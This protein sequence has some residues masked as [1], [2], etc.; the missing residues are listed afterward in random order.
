MTKSITHSL[1]WIALIGINVYF[2]YNF[3]LQH[4]NYT[5]FSQP[6]GHLLTVHIVFGIVAILV[7]PFQ[8]FAAIRKRFVRVHR[9]SGR[10]YLLSVLVAATTAILLSVNDNLLTK[11]E[12]VFGTGTLG[13][14]AAWLIT[15]GMAF[16]AI[17]TR[18]FEQHREWM[19]RS[20]VVTCGFTTF[21]IIAVTLHNTILPNVPNLGDAAAW[22]CWAVPLLFTEAI[23]QGQKMMRAPAA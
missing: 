12:I 10:L 4:F 9:F 3:P 18:R 1:L 8:F 15:S 22:A 13:L 14:A 20:Y 17:R 5:S 21:R 19:I 2:V 6:F 7:G 23:L 11:H 16:W